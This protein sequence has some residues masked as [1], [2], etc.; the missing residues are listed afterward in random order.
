MATLTSAAPGGSAWWLAA[1]PRTLPVAVAPVAVGSACAVADDVFVAAPALAAG[2][3]ALLLQVGANFANDAFD[4]LRGADGPDRTGPPRA[5]ALGL[6][7][8][9]ALLA[10]T[11]VA[12]AGAALAGSFLALVAGWPVVAIGAAGML[13]A[14]GYVG[15]GAYGYRGLGEPAVFL[16]FGMIAVGGTYWVQAGHLPA[17]V[18]LVAL[19]VACLAT[20]VLVVNNVRDLASD[21]RAG[22]NTLAVRLGPRGARL[23]Y[24]ALLLVAYGSLPVIAWAR[25]DAGVLLP[26]LTVPLALGLGRALFRREGAALN[27]VL[28]RTAGLDA[29]FAFLL[30]LGL[31]A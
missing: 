17:A 3:G 22:K 20:A 6:L 24:A 28:A 16:F 13:A 30:A 18:A 27:A 1:R 8:P 4:H 11:A 26:L 10:G 2:L 21:R 23:E 31:L 7:S 19:P 14:I 29:G 12:F 5:A 15:P 25:R 9:R